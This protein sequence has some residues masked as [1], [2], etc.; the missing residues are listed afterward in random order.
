MTH[1]RATD[2]EITTHLASLSGWRH[3]GEKLHKTFN[4]EDFEVAFGWMT[5]VAGV[6]ETLGHHPEWFNVY[7]R[8]EVALQTH[9]VSPPG[10]TDVDLR[11]A[12]AMDEL[13]G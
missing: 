4:F 10:V 6:A 12:T 7:N 2:T 13:A 5:K 3:E 1:H 9:D 8:V 11:L